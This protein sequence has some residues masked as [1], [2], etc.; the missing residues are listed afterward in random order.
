MLY[1]WSQ[2]C[3][4]NY[5]LVEVTHQFYCLNPFEFGGLDR[6][7]VALL[8]VQQIDPHDIQSKLSLMGRKDGK[9]KS[10]KIEMQLRVWMDFASDL[11]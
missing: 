2:K 4:H 1:N 5:P 6:K 11:E 9:V 10:T 8:L 3:N 7:S